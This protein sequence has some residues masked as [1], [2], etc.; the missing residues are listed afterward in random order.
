[1]WGGGGFVA[2]KRRRSWIWGAGGGPWRG[3]QRGAVAICER[4][5]SPGGACAVRSTG[6]FQ[7]ANPEDPENPACRPPSHYYIAMSDPS[8]GSPSVAPRAENRAICTRRADAARRDGDEG[9][10]N[11]QRRR[12]S[13]CPS[14]PP[15]PPTSQRLRGRRRAP[16]EDGPRARGL[17]RHVPRSRGQ[18]CW[19]QRVG[20]VESARLR[21]RERLARRLPRRG[22]TSSLPELHGARER[23]CS[24]LH[25][26][27]DRFGRRAQVRQ[28]RRAPLRQPRRAAGRRHC[29]HRRGARLRGRRN[30]HPPAASGHADSSH[31]GSK[32]APPTA[33]SSQ[34]TRPRL[35][36]EQRGGG[37]AHAPTA[38]EHARANVPAGVE[39]ARRPVR[40]RRARRYSSRRLDARGNL[41]PQHPKWPWTLG[42]LH[43]SRSAR[44]G[45]PHSPP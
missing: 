8:T 11:S 33:A 4:A 22:R 40:A 6:A 20:E 10:N 2:E 19:R 24:R 35:R 18:R 21:E 42:A 43:G 16:R 23:E 1:M 9:G 5:R 27:Q 3:A 15:L 28:P 25:P 26:G 41:S 39:R 32:A 29:A 34:I 37:T 12:L 17:A 14:R 30:A 31:R 45:A 36:A 7:S 38:P 13:L 44:G